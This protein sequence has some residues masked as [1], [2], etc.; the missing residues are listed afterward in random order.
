MSI[1]EMKENLSHILGIENLKMRYAQNGDQIYMIGDI[2]TQV[3]PMASE[4]QI[5]NALLKA[6]K[7]QT[8]Q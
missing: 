2:S 5:E 4:Q 8:A 3:G 1:R 6:M 7:Q